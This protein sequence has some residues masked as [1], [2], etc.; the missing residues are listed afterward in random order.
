MTLGPFDRSAPPHGVAGGGSAAA[1]AH[2]WERSYPPGV[3]WHQPVP[4]EP[5][6]LALDRAVA[7]HGDRP[8]LD[9]LGRSYSYAEVG[10]LVARTTRG[11]QDIG[12]V[13]GTRVALFLPN[14][15]YYVACYFAVVKLGG[16][17]VNVNPL[18]TARE[19][20]YQLNDAGAETIV[21]F[22]GARPVL[23]EI[24]GRT[25]VKTVITVDARNTNGGEFGSGTA[26][27]ARIT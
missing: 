23:A 19:L 14:T 4:R 20:E 1:A 9:F 16:I 24:I 10:D 2:R 7:E 15:P 5:L 21:I 22:E 12:V 13:K 6:W 26:A 18:Y 17:V 3:D 11:L 8:C 25:R 27:R